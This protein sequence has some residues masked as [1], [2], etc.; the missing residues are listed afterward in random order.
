MVSRP[1]AGM[2]YGFKSLFKRGWRGRPWALDERQGERWIELSRH[3]SKKEAA[4][5]LE[6]RTTVEPVDRSAL[7]MRKVR[8][9]DG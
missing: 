4:A 3:V 5:A 7:R 1:H 6:R 2:G 8:G 9:A